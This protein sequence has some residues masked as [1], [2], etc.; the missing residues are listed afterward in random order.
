MRIFLVLSL[1]DCA[2]ELP[3][4]RAELVLLDTNIQPVGR[5]VGASISL[6]QRP[7]RFRRSRVERKPRPGRG[8]PSNRWWLPHGPERSPDLCPAPRLPTSAPRWPTRL[9]PKT[10]SST[11]FKSSRSR[12]TDISFADGARICPGRHPWMLHAT[13]AAPGDL[14][15]AL[16]LVHPPGRD[17]AR[18]SARPRCRGEP[19]SAW[20]AP[21][22]LHP[23]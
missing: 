18:P 9:D 8:Q 20:P 11:M 15:L 4:L 19:R 6:P 5:R 1:R 22:P 23:H 14:P 3:V 13:C 21:R 2:S 10:T 12:F 17:S 7:A 16:L